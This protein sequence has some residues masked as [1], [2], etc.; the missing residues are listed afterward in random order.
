MW[1]RPL[2]T[3]PR[4]GRSTAKGADH[5]KALRPRPDGSAF[6][7]AGSYRE[8]AARPAEDGSDGHAGRE[9][10]GPVL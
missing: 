8:A 4:T 2:S 7:V 5:F 9:P 3:N 6:D 10:P 1:C